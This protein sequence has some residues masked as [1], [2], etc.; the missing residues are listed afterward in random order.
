MLIESGIKEDSSIGFN[1]HIGFRAGTGFPFLLYD[2]TTEKSTELLEKPLAFM[3]S[4]CWHESKKNK[5]KFES[6][7]TE[8]FQNNGFNTHIVTNFHNSFFNEALYNGIDFKSMYLNFVDS[9]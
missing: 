8:F 7:F 1:R 6:L 3:D 5:E 4:S 9:L 2:F